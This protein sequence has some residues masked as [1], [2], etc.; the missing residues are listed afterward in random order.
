MEEP[1]AMYIVLLM[2]AKF[3]LI[4][5]LLSDMVFG[6]L[7]LIS[8]PETE[9][10]ILNDDGR[11]NNRNL[12]FLCVLCKICLVKVESE[13]LV[14][15]EDAYQRFMYYYIE[16]KRLRVVFEATSGHCLHKLHTVTHTLHTS[17]TTEHDH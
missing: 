6:P 7:V 10:L 3:M 1:R 2:L 4:K 11:Q 9:V 8:T 13:Y 17:C 15:V 14:C 16:D 12:N 5:I